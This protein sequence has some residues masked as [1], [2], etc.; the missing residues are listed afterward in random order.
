MSGGSVSGYVGMA[1]GIIGAITGICGA[2]MGYVAYRR[3][4]KYKVLDWRIDLKKG[5]STSFLMHEGILELVAEA[6]KS[7]KAV[8]AATGRFR[9][10]AMEKWNRDVEQDRT[11]I[12]QLISGLPGPNESYDNVSAEGLETKIVEMH[13]LQEK[14]KSYL[15]KYKKF[16]A[17]DDESR[18]FLRD[19]AHSKIR[20]S[21]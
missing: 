6:D 2:V 13:K 12:E 1:T 9:S 7:R 8:Y 19:Q 20:G 18:R 21:T 4:N 17:E 15:T 5:L 11:S 16:L 3:S 10:G 14:L